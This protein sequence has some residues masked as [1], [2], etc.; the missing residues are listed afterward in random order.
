MKNETLIAY[1]EIGPSYIGHYVITIFSKAS[2][3]CYGCIACFDGDDGSQPI[4]IL[5]RDNKTF[6]YFKHNIGSNDKSINEIVIEDCEVAINI[7]EKA[8]K[9]SI[10]TLRKIKEFDKQ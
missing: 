8:Y 1:K 3:M 4:Y 2:K 7:L 9:D 6:E 10:N 5:I